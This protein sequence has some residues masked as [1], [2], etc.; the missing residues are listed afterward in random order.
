MSFNS[1]QHFENRN[2]Q[3]RNSTRALNMQV[4]IIREKHGT[5]LR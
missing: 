3:G 4:V 5:E 2:F 1:T